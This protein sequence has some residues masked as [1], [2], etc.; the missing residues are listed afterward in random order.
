MDNRISVIVPA[1]NAAPWLSESID[2]LLAQTCKNMEIL[3]VDDGSTDNTPQ[4]LAGYG[5][6]IRVI[7]QKNAG[8][9]AARL[10]GVSAAAGDW[11]GFLDADDV[12]EPQMYGR[13]LENALRYGGDISHC[14]FQEDYE[15]GRTV[16][17]HNTGAIRQQDRLTALK[18]LLEEA[19][20]E[21][22]LY[23][24]LFRRELF[25]GLERK[26]DR[27]IRNN[28][29]M[30]MNYFLFQKAE[31][32]VYEDVSP[33]HYR[34]RQGSASRRKPNEHLL[35]DP[36]RVRQIILAD[37]GEEL[38]EDAVRALVRMCLVSF[39]AVSVENRQEYRE[40]QQKLTEMLRQMREYLPLLSKKNALQLRLV[41]AWPGAY[42]S[43]YRGFARLFRRGF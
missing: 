21:P 10:A 3:V 15:D 22:A 5:D 26:M 28:E 11:I 19:E 24:K 2:S 16:C 36:I 8:V 13:L 12:A 30:L 38:R 35:Y 27:S 23:T 31:K 18:E 34:I 41:C 6:R 20:I 7:R 29:D 17:P 4:V 42:R 32:A 14:G 37:C 40:D 43:L 39:R 9:T 25:E 33:Y 1:Y